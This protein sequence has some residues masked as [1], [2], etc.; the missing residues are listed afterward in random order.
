[1]AE[2]K[3]SMT[4]VCAQI[5]PEREK[6]GKP[7]CVCV[8]CGKE[9][10]NKRGNRKSGEGNKYCS[11]ECAYSHINE[12]ANWHKVKRERKTAPFSNVFFKVCKC[13]NKQFATRWD[14]KETC[15]SEC[16]H[17]ASLA[18]LRREYI[19]VDKKSKECATCK[20]QFKTN[21][22]T[23][24][25][26]SRDC[27]PK[28]SSARDRARRVGAVYEIVNVIRVFDRDGWRCQICGR[29]TPKNKRGTIHKNAPELDH[30]VP[31]A[32]GGSHTYDN[33]QCACRECNNK[34]GGYKIAG[35]LPLLSA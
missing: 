26:C 32:L 20:N 22:E 3:H 28:R 17:D 16:A 9:Y 19:P 25:Y 29:L 31:F 14:K 4:L 11:R 7:Q 13:C 27:V 23:Q 34:K 35:Q 2:A 30:R 33:V 1:M 21:R 10:T 15:S 12:W 18:R 6:E 5:I 24:V 8:G